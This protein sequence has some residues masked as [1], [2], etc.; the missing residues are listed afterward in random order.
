MTTFPLAS[1]VP[2][3]AGLAQRM[4]SAE[5][6]ASPSGLAAQGARAFEPQTATIVDDDANTSDP[7][8]DANPASPLVSNAEGQHP[9]RHHGRR[10]FHGEHHRH[11]PHHHHHHYHH[12]GPP[13]FG[14]GSHGGPLPPG[15]EP[16]HPHRRPHG[17]RSPRPEGTVIGT[18]CLFDL[19]STLQPADY[20]LTLL[21]DDSDD[22]ESSPGDRTQRHRNRHRSHR[23][24]RDSAEDTGP[25]PPWRL[26]SPA[27]LVVAMAYLAGLPPPSS[28]DLDDGPSR[29]LHPGSRRHAPFPHAYGGPHPHPSGFA[30]EG[31]GRGRGGRHAYGFDFAFGPRPPFPPPPFPPTGRDFYNGP[32]GP[33]HFGPPGPPPPPC[34]LGDLGGFPPP[35][36]P[37]PPPT[38]VTDIC[39]HRHRGPYMRGEPGWHD[40]GRGFHPF[41][42]HGGGGGGFR[43]H[44]GRHW[45]RHAPWATAW[46]DDLGS[47]DGASVTP[48]EGS[49]SLSARFAQAVA[50]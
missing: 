16:G 40:H 32:S 9:R 15:F 39:G 28:E 19:D 18:T 22:D 11:R 31:C 49:P 21:S 47:S 10:G 1:P 36:P 17:R 4:A 44:G 5:I 7:A 43:P 30:F 46:T 38:D 12:R 14:R 26:L 42:P 8:D 48:R 33:P 45:A 3:A 27:D 13:D 34:S 24:H 29:R 2:A 25:C 20:R 41:G 6:P 37:P 23:H 50:V 35:P